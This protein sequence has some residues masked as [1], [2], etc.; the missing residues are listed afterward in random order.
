LQ[1]AALPASIVEAEILPARIDAY[2]AA[3]L[4]AL[5]AAGEVTWVG[6]ERLGEHDGRVALYLADDLARLQ[7]PVRA[8][9]ETPPDLREAKIVE[10][11]K[12]HGASFFGPLH[13][14]AGGGYPAETVNAIWRLV[15]DGR[16]TNDTLQALRAFTRSHGPRRRTKPARRPP[17]RSRRLVPASAEG[18]WS[19]VGLAPS[20]ARS[21]GAATEWAAA[22]TQQLL[23][24]HGV[25]TRE[26]VGAESIPGGFGI[27]YPVLKAMEDAGRIRRGY[28][29]ARLGATQF[30]LPGAL[31]LLRSLRVP[32]EPPGIVVL[33]ATDPANPYG[34]TLPWPHVPSAVA[35]TNPT[36]SSTIDARAHHAEAAPATKAGR[37]PTR[38]VGA[39]VIMVDGVLVAYLARGDRS[40]LTWIPDAEP[41][42]S[43]TARGVAQALITRA[44]Q[45]VAETGGESSDDQPDEGSRRGMLIE[46]IDGAPPALHPIVPSLVEAGFVPGAMGLHAKR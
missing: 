22:I 45:R 26:A 8:A 20:G 1:G 40:L 4:D 10:Y 12:T 37:G 16:L 42:R 31:D 25:L 3:D 41:A 2:D 13:E 14:A 9:K 36:K 5:I 35:R 6:V 29:V 11:L 30:A 46:E 15:W 18:R 44:R 38:S 27:V 32:S 21:V 24:R 23:A 28:F 7:P 19:L 17:F 34:A 43:N 33:A 39:T